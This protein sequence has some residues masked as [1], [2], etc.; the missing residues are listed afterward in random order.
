MTA[1]LLVLYS[2]PK[3]TSAFD[4]YY[5]DHHLPLVKAIPGLRSAACSV[6][7]VG[8]P[9]GP[10]DHHQVSTYTWD[11]LAALQEGLGSPEAA[12][13]GADLPNLAPDGATMLVYEEEDL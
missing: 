1:K 3:D 8:T 4:A 10:S 6:G 13:A 2:T 5:R 12:A 11:S 7:P 9:A